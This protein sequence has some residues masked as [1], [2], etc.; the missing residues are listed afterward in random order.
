MAALDRQRLPVLTLDEAIPHLRRPFTPEAIRFKVQSVFKQQDGTPFGCLIVAYIDAR[1]AGERLNRVIPDGWSAKYEVI[2]GTKLMW[3]RLTVDGVTREDVGESPKG[4]SKDLVSDALK[5]AAVHFGV[6]VSCYALPQIKLTMNEA[7]GRI[8]IRGKGDKRT[9]ALTEHGHTK[10]REGYSKWLEEHGIPRFGPPLDHGDV[11]GATI[12]ESV[13]EEETGIGV[14][15]GDGSVPPWV[16]VS[17][18]HI[19][20]IE[21]L[22]ARAESIGFPGLADMATVRMR[23]NHQPPHAVQDWIDAAE[24][25]LAAV[26]P[27]D[28]EVVGEEG[29]GE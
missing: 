3:C 16:G 17:D 18:E 13:P 28:A 10:L 25:Q 9:I 14:G 8:E 6:G 27:K 20:V 26:E 19:A 12:D 5:R 21:G 11:V 15:D 2:L 1:L 22:M 29:E 4:L 7:H 23:L 24:E